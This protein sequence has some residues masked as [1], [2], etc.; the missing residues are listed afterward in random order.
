MSILWDDDCGMSSI[1]K[2]S[3][4]V[5]DKKKE[6]RLKEAKGKEDKEKNVK[7]KEKKM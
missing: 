5:E 2:R 4:K 1:C 3:E 7:G 6:D